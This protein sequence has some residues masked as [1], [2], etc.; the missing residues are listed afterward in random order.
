MILQI[1]GKYITIGQLLK[2]FGYITTGG[3]AK[4]FLQK[5]TIKINGKMPQGRNTKVFVSSTIWI[6]DDVFKIEQEK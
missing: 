1:Y 5:N 6:N 4:Q 2:K 3:Q